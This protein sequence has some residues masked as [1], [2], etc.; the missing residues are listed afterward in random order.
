MNPKPNPTNAMFTV[1]ALPF[2]WSAPAL[3]AS[4]ATTARTPPP[5]WAPMNGWLFGT[6]L[7]LLIITTIA[8]FAFI[9]T[10]LYEK[11]STRGKFSLKMFSLGLVLLM[12]CVMFWTWWNSALDQA[13][14]DRLVP[15]TLRGDA[16]PSFAT[17]EGLLFFFFL[18]L[19]FFSAVCLV[20]FGIG[21]LTSD[22]SGLFGRMTVTT[23]Y[24][25]PHCKAKIKLFDFPLQ[26][27]GRCRAC[28]RVFSV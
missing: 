27:Q 20:V 18:L 3:W 13:A 1:A 28:G 6:C 21:M 16:D 9:R 23:R 22:T 2:A 10:R 11:S 5:L 19:S 26:G 25:C 17:V 14:R 4:E 24:L 8:A 7:V 12:P 15:L